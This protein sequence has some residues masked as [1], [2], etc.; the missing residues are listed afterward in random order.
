MNIETIPEAKGL[1]SGI[2][3]NLI[4]NEM[5]QW[6]LAVINHPK[7]K[8]RFYKNQRINTIFFKSNIKDLCST[9]R[10]DKDRLVASDISE[11]IDRLQLFDPNEQ[12]VAWPK[13][14]S[15]S[16]NDLTWTCQHCHFK[17]CPHC[18]LATLSNWAHD[19]ILNEKLSQK[20]KEPDFFSFNWEPMDSLA[21]ASKNDIAIAK[22]LLDK[23][24]I[25]VGKTMETL[26]VK[27]KVPKIYIYQQS[28]IVAD[29]IN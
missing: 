22:T 25:Y 19:G 17:V 3:P 12:I 11:T 1:M 21:D 9:G 13:H 18:L 8:G 6:G 2:D 16:F 29:L 10:A 24:L 26:D 5:L 7:Y 20:T 14:R 23:G 4:P 27:Y 15:V 28:L